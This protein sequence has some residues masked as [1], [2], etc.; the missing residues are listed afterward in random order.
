MCIRDR[1]HT[2]MKFQY[3]F[4]NKTVGYLFLRLS[5]SMNSFRLN[6]FLIDV[7]KRQAEYQEM[8]EAIKKNL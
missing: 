4:D 8:I 7:Y 5:S 1:Y 6:T 3:M 2:G